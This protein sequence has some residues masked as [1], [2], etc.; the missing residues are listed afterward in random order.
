MKTDKT[1]ELLIEL[2]ANASAIEVV[3]LYGS[4]A[5][6]DHQADSDYDLAIAVKTDNISVRDQYFNDE[7]AYQWSNSSHSKIS[8]VDIND[9]P[10]PLAISVVNDGKVLLSKNDLRLHSEMQR[11]WSLW[12]EYRYEY[13]KQRK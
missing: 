10:V 5:R 8:V 1:V 2:A 7:L 6:E 9:I 4:R 11:I 13:I 3:W 12:E